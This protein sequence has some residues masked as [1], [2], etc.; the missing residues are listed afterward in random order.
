[1]KIVGIKNLFLKNFRIHKEFSCNIEHN[2]IILIGNNG[3]GKTSIL[4]AITLLSPGKG[5]L[6]ANSKDLNY[7]NE[8]KSTIIADFNDTTN[9]CIENKVGNKN[10]LV[11]GKSLTKQTDLSTWCDIVWFTADTQYT[12]LLSSG[13]RRK[14]FDRM[15]FALFNNHAILLTDY[16]KLSKERVKILLLEGNNN[17]WLDAIEKQLSVIGAHVAKNRVYFIEECNKE[18]VNNILFQ[19]KI[20]ADGLLENLTDNVSEKFEEILKNNRIKDR[21]SGRN[22]VGPH[23]TDFSILNIQSGESIDKVSSGKQ[24]MFLLSVFETFTRLITIKNQRTPIILFDEIS[25]FVD[26][27]NFNKIM[28]SFT[29]NK[30]QIWMASPRK[31]DLFD[32]YDR[33]IIEF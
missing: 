32:M 13:N 9:I 2:N 25:S 24:K 20:I 15:V 18:C 31:Y 8:Q 17:K 29:N 30:A 28:Q 33:Q 22:N 16:D 1:M 21:E 6:A 12:F 14:F 26:H 10:I 19:V 27:D 4:E 23:R 3:S 5:M 7:N 11:N